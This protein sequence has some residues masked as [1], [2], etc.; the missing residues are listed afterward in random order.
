MTVTA[1]QGVVSLAACNTVIA[2]IAV[3]NI[4]ATTAADIVVAIAAMN[5]IVDLAASHS[6]MA[7]TRID[8]AFGVL[9]ETDEVRPAGSGNLHRIHTGPFLAYISSQQDSVF[10]TG[11]TIPDL[12]PAIMYGISGFGHIDDAFNGLPMR[13]PACWGCF[14]HF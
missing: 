14:C 6:V 7:G 2:S 4:I 5:K 9:L 1:M 3:D 13:G 8:S 10:V 11:F 12:F